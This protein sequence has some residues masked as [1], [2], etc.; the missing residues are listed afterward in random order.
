MASEIIALK[1]GEASGGG[2]GLPSQH[3]TCPQ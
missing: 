2:K 3:P 1:W